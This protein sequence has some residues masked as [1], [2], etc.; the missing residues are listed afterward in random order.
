MYQE[1]SELGHSCRADIDVVHI[2]HPV[3]DC[4]NIKDTA[5]TNS[6]G[7][8]IFQWLLKPSIIALLCH[9]AIKPDPTKIFSP[10]NYCNL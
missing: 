5:Q 1:G 2:H 10:L 8:A 9:N 4:R 7:Q 3:R 6:N